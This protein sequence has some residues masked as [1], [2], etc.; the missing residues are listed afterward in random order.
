MLFQGPPCRRSGTRFIPFDVAK[1][2]QKTARHLA[3]QIDP[4]G[5]HFI[6]DL[7]NGFLHASVTHNIMPTISK[8]RGG[9]GAYYHTKLQRRLDSHER[10]KAQAQGCMKTLDF[11]I[12]S[13]SQL[14][15]MVG[16]AMS[17][18]WCVRS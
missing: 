15:D 6:I 14:G 5:E 2:N 10:A 17:A 4:R 7:N 1:L 12:L 3:P 13:P 11:S 8:A 18:R 16:N 9:Q